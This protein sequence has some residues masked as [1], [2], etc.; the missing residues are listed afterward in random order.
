[1]FEEVLG[2]PA[3]P[4]MVH[5]AVVLVP[6]LSLLAGGYA[7]VPTQR[8]RLEPALVA[9]A[10]GAP[11]AVGVA[12]ESG[13][14]FRRR[15]AA[16]RMLPSELAERVDTHAQFGRTLLLLTLALAA[17]AIGLVLLERWRGQTGN[18]PPT[19]RAH[20]AAL[21]IV[22]LA[23]AGVA[24]WYVVETGHSGSSMVWRGS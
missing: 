23:L 18:P 2:L 9:L 5:A 1:M 11:L 10:V 16:R 19:L 17:A 13:E 21:T 20:T 7:L 22:I 24:T 6:L 3:H 15:L 14:A 8:G 4:L 12:R